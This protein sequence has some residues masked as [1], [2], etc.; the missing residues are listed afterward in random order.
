MTSRLE[1]SLRWG[2]LTRFWQVQGAGF[3][4]FQKHEKVFGEKPVVAYRRPRSL[5]E[6]LVRSRIKKKATGYSEVMKNFGKARS[7]ICR[8]VVA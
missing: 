6:E 3:T 1:T 5:R 4:C 7:Q 2:L 8:Y